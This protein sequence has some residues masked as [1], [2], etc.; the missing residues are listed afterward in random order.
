MK[1]KI[2]QRW[3]AI[4]YG[5]IY[6]GPYTWYSN[7]VTGVGDKTLK[8]VRGSSLGL[9]NW[10]IK[11]WYWK[12]V[13]VLNPIGDSFV[14]FQIGFWDRKRDIC[15]VSSAIR[16]VSDGPFAMRLG[17]DNCDFFIFGTYEV[18]LE[19]LGYDRTDNK[20]LNYIIY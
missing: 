13:I 2:W 1:S 3:T 12:R 8:P 9:F 17:P 19:S 5:R 14:V 6:I 15:M 18:E 7:F 16:K 11:F 10:L 20:N 4:K